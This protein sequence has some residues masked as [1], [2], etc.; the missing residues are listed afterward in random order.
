MSARGAI[1]DNRGLAR[2]ELWYAGEATLKAGNE[3]RTV[4]LVPDMWEGTRR[5]DRAVSVEL[6]PP[7]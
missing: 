5:V 1:A 6:E 7:G 4:T 3:S 2:I